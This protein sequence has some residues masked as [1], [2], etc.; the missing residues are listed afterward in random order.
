MKKNTQQQKL[1][2]KLLPV[3]NICKGHLV[4]AHRIIIHQICR[5]QYMYQYCKTRRFNIL[6]FLSNYTRVKYTVHVPHCL[7][8]TLRLAPFYWSLDSESYRWQ[9]YQIIFRC[10]SV[11]SWNIPNSR[12]KPSSFFH[13]CFHQY[14]SFLYLI[15]VN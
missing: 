6:K 4:S 1:P 15:C 3:A 2:R 10:K 13:S 9:F 7:P 11:W 8:M 5:I 12:T 14:F